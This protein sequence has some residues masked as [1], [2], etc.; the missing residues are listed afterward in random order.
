LLS[1]KCFNINICSKSGC[2]QKDTT[3]K[4]D[5][6]IE[7]GVLFSLLLTEDTSLNKTSSEKSEQKQASLISSFVAPC[8]VKAKELNFWV[9]GRRRMK[10]TAAESTW[11]NLGDFYICY[12]DSA[13]QILLELAFDIGF[14]KIST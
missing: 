6:L 13:D 14:C 3:D 9:V 11:K 12:H 7:Q 1:N 8:S 10:R 2:F 5:L 4:N